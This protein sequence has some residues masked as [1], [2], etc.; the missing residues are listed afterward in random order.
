M[1]QTAREGGDGQSDLLD[2]DVSTKA[3]VVDG[4]VSDGV[5]TP[6]G[7]V[8][9]HTLRDAISRMLPNAG[10][11]IFE[12]NVIVPRSGL[13]AETMRRLSDFAQKT[14][15]AATISSAKLSPDP[16]ARKEAVVVLGFRGDMRSSM[17]RLLAA[18]QQSVEAEIVVH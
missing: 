6:E 3:F 10:V 14:G 11:Q 17:E 1:T 12:G 13:D 5:D 9:L 18:N 7:H 15:V 16:A 8:N 2:G 4:A